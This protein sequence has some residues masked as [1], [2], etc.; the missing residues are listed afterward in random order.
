MKYKKTIAGIIVAFGALGAVSAPIVPVSDGY[1]VRTAPSDKAQFTKVERNHDLKGLTE[2]HIIGSA[3]YDRFTDPKG[4]LDPIRQK[5]DCTEYWNRANIADYPVPKIEGMIWGSYV[6]HLF[7]TPSGDLEAGYYSKTDDVVQ[8]SVGEVIL[9]ATTPSVSAAIS[10]DA[11]SDQTTDS[12][13]VSSL[14]WSHTVTASASTTVLIVG[15]GMGD[16]TDSDRTVNALTFNGDSLFKVREDDENTDNISTAVWQMPDPTL[17]TKT[18]TVT[19][20]AA[21][22]I[23]DAGALSIHGVDHYTP[24]DAQASSMAAS[25][26]IAAAVTT[27]ADNTWV[28]AVGAAIANTTAAYT[29]VSPDVGIGSY[30]DSTGGDIVTGYFG[31]KTP[32]GSASVDWSCATICTSADWISSQ[33]SFDPN[34]NS[35]GDICSQRWR[36]SGTWVAPANLTSVDVAC[37]GG[38]GG[39]GGNRAGGG[40]GGAFASS[41]VSVTAGNSYAIVVGTGGAVDTILTT[42]T[43]SFN[44]TSVVADGGYGVAT[45][46]TAGG[47]RGL[48]L[49]S[50]GTVTSNGG[51]GGAG[52]TGGSSAGGGGGG[53]GGP[54]GAGAVGSA[55]S[56]TA[57]GP[58]GTGDNTLGGA[59]GAEGKQGETSRN[60]GGGGGGGDATMAAGSGAV[61]GAGG[62]GGGSGTNGAAGA[63]GECLLVWTYHSAPATGGLIDSIIWFLT[64]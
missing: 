43:S 7:D 36:S 38:G 19:L 57:G 37:W 15:V 61:L 60:G 20:N 24:V 58:G 8:E 55:G 52:S 59:G 48:A 44:G 25:G 45:T 18:I 35:A 10:L 3:C 23:A 30:N 40:G 4:I 28:F 13:A 17:G 31:P 12:T 32:A 47:L 42:A 64:D 26:N 27:V 2:A 56:G 46:Q 62:G 34:C 41:T 63:P 49:L 53:A 51:T 39:G 14:S 5:I 9:E 6:T 16:S 11:V 1:Y 54:D 50:T 21:N 33:V 29:I 22:T